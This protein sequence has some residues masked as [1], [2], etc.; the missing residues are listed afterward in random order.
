M[1]RL[2]ADACGAYLFTLQVHVVVADL[3]VDAKEVDE[4]DKVTEENRMSIFPL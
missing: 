3:E 4:G 2:S 1:L